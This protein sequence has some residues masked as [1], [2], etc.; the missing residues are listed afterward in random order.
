MR[1]GQISDMSVKEAIL[2]VL[3]KNPE[4]RY[5]KLLRPCGILKYMVKYRFSLLT[6]N[7]P[8]IRQ[9][10]LAYEVLQ[11]YICR[12][13]AWFAADTEMISLR[14]WDQVKCPPFCSLWTALLFM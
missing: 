10:G 11:W 5:Q 14:A 8:L 4:L 2:I 6:V 1:D 12:M 3:E 9:E 13:E 7:M